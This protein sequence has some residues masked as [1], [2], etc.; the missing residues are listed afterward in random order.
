MFV[1]IACYLDP[2]EAHIVLGRLQAEGLTGYV[3]D[4][5]QIIADWGWR[6][7]L[8]GAKVRVPRDQALEAHRLLDAIAAGEFLSEGERATGSFPDR[9]TPSVRLAYFALFVLQLP[10]PWRRRPLPDDDIANDDRQA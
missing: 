5:H 4:S 8:G 7:A 3:A 9:D 2:M 6:L 1:T 10:L